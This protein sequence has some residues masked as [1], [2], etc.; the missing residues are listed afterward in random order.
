MNWSI[1]MGSIYIYGPE[2]FSI[3]LKLF[4]N[5]VTLTLSGNESISDIN[6]D[7]NRRDDDIIINF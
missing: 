6:I 1:V 5:M 3:Q 4:Y 2:I 7:T